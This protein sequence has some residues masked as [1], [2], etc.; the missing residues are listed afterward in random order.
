VEVFSPCPTH[1]GKNNAM[2]ETRE[3]LHWLKEKGLPVEEFN[4]LSR[5]A[6]EGY[7]PVGKLVDRDEPDFNARYEAIRLRATAKKG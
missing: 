5:P 3:M 6:R 1:F 2:K 4:R 7:F